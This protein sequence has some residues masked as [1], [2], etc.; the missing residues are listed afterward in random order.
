MRVGLVVKVIPDKKIGFI[1]T[2]DLRDDIFFHFSVVD[3]P[4]RR[5][6]AEGDEVE[7]E[8]DE[9]DRLEKRKLRASVVRR[10]LRPLSMRLQ[11]SDAPELQS[12]HH[13]N[14]RQRKP[15]WRKKAG[16]DSPGLTDTPG[17][18]ANG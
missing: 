2:D 17:E 3:Q 7:F 8:I 6:L 4:G 18:I 13:P 11:A 14:A 5:E 10:T 16:S 12:Q 15:N 1:H 9:L